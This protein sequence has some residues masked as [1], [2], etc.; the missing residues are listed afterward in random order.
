MQIGP[1]LPSLGGSLGKAI[2]SV[3]EPIKH[4]ATSPVGLAVLGTVLGGPLGGLVSK[5]P[6]AG[7]IAS[8]ATAAGGALSKIPGAAAIGS[9]AK[10]ALLGKDGKFGLDDIGN[11]VSLGSGVMSGVEGYNNGQKADDLRQQALDAATQDYAARAPLRTQGQAQMLAVG[12]SNPFATNYQA[13][14]L[15]ALPSVGGPLRR[16]FPPQQAA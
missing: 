1:R 4:A 7:S 5:I 11:L 12:K 3:T 9:A 15:A 8:A 6:G 10:G 16:R 2:G 14:G 13:P